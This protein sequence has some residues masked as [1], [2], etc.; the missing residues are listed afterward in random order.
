[1]DLFKMN[2]INK[3]SKT[4]YE[5][6]SD[7]M[8]VQNI[9]NL[10]DAKRAL[11]SE[12]YQSLVEEYKE[13]LNNTREYRTNLTMYEVRASQIVYLL[14]GRTEASY[15]RFCGDAYDI[16]HIYSGKKAIIEEIL[17]KDY[18]R[19]TDLL[20]L[21]GEKEEVIVDPSLD[22]KKIYINTMLFFKDIFDGIF[23]LFNNYEKDYIYRFVKEYNSK[24]FLQNYFDIVNGDF[25]SLKR[26]GTKIREIGKECFRNAS[27][28][29]TFVD[30]YMNAFL[31]LIGKSK[32]QECKDE[33]KDY[34]CSFILD[35]YVN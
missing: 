16:L 24:V 17:K 31:N 18:D 35:L 27:S 34:I 2:R 28:P 14:E 21:F 12:Q 23:I 13:L 10:Q 8:I 32:N 4:H 6:I 9:V 33:L 3:L 26:D 22:F 30:S 5:M 20:W 19:M 1:M 15:D 7:A 29:I 25:E 11:S